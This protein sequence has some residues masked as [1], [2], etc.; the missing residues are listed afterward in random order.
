[1]NKPNTVLYLTRMAGLCVWTERLPVLLID[2]VTIGCFHVASHAVSFD[3][4]AVILF[5]NRRT[6]T[7]L[8]AG[9]VYIH[10]DI[11]LCRYMCTYILYMY[12]L[13]VKYYVL[14]FP[15]SLPVDTQ[16]TYTLSVLKNNKNKKIK[17][18]FPNTSTKLKIYFLMKS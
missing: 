14:S 3:T 7:V 6:F 15:P 13:L 8:R 4:K 16:D 17:I 5:W 2:I 12:L 10:T 9:C 18:T 1:M 11:Q